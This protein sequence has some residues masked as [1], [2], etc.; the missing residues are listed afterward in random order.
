LTWFTTVRVD[1]HSAMHK[2][3]AARPR[4]VSAARALSIAANTAAITDTTPAA[5]KASRR[6]RAVEITLNPL[7]NPDTYAETAAHFIL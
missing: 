6:T 4:R 1:V 5:A 2:A 7:P 3:A